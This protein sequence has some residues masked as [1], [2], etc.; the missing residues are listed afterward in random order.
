MDC[1]IWPSHAASTELKVTVFGFTS[2]TRFV[3]LL[4]LIENRF[5]S[6]TCGR[7]ATVGPHAV[8]TELKLTVFGLANIRVARL[9]KNLYLI[10]NRFGSPSR[11]RITAVRPCGNDRAK[12]VFD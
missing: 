10:E 3:Q 2:V 12:S 9:F 4:H 6:L 8:I 5:G 7:I 11:R 1:H